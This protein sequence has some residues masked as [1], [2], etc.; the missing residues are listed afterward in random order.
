VGGVHELSHL[1]ADTC[2]LFHHLIPVDAQIYKFYNPPSRRD[3][4]RAVMQSAEFV[5]T[6]L[7]R[8]RATRYARHVACESGDALVVSVIERAPPARVWLDLDDALASAE[9]VSSQRPERH[10]TGRSWAPL[11]FRPWRPDQLSLAEQVEGIDNTDI[12]FGVHGSGLTLG[13]YMGAG[14]AVVQVLPPWHCVWHIAEEYQST[15][16]AVGA[17]YVPLCMTPS[18][19]VMHG[20]PG[21]EYLDYLKEYEEQARSG[22]DT[23]QQWMM[24]KIK[25]I[26]LSGPLLLHGG[27]IARMQACGRL[28]ETF[29]ER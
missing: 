29:A 27:R 23:G 19:I 16:M 10:T 25:G 2:L 7:N 17:S 12:L 1:A 21:Q 8:P 20:S 26:Y 14:Q 9:T 15:V 28:A 13:M 4:Y 24:E 18:E 6:V 22:W 3:D 5:R 11:T